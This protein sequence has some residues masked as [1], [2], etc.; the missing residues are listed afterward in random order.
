MNE[1]RREQHALTLLCFQS[2]M[3]VLVIGSCFKKRKKEKILCNQIN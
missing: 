1:S 2:D 3:T